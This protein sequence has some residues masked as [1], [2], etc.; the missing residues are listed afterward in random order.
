MARTPVQE[1]GKEKEVHTLRLEVSSLRQDALAS[2]SSNNAERELSAG[3]ATAAANESCGLQAEIASLQLAAAAAAAENVDLRDRKAVLRRA[4]EDERAAF[5]AALS[6]CEA[7]VDVAKAKLKELK[8]QICCGL[9]C[10][11]CQ[12]RSAVNSTGADASMC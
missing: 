8:E 2:A 6:A 10:A 3:A 5:A 7:R 9:L 1:M 11:S 12:Q 4:L